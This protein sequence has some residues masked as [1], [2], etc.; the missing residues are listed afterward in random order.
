MEIVNI[1]VVDLQ[2]PQ[3]SLQL[4]NDVVAGTA[5]LVHVVGACAW[6]AASG[7]F[8]TNFGGDDYFAPLSGLA[9]NLTDELLGMGIC[10]D[11]CC[12]D[13]VDPEIQALMEDLLRP[14]EIC[15]SAK[16][17]RPDAKNRDIEASATKLA[18]FRTPFSSLWI[19]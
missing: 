15:A 10:V 5:T 16:I 9:D 7:N 8:D 6:R 13:E 12:I 2:A 14:L 11:V 18:V 17:I 3:T 19:I 1:D 4:L